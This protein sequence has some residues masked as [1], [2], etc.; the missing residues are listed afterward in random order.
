M[1]EL[2]YLPY[3]RIA[4]VVRTDFSDDQTWEALG[5]AIREPTP[6]DFSPTWTSST[7]RPTAA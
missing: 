2:P 7:I 4:L 1:N 6:E 3:R 5:E